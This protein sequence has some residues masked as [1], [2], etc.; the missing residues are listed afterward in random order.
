MRSIYY[1]SDYMRNV[2]LLLTLLPTDSDLHRKPPTVPHLCCSLANSL[3]PVPLSLLR[4]VRKRHT[5]F[6]SS[7]LVAVVLIKHNL[8][9]AQVRVCVKFYCKLGKN[10]T[11]IC[12][13]LIQAYDED[14]MSQTQCYEWFKLFKEGRMSIG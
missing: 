4:A 10:Y 8:S 11:K 9:N 7:E 5:K 14:C 13:L 3:S 2:L 1:V 12:Q 6:I